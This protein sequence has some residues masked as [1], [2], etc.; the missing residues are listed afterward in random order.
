MPAAPTT[1]VATAPIAAM[2]SARMIAMP[3]MQMAMT[4]GEEAGEGNH[5]S[6]DCR[7]FQR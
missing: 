3:M 2:A 4:A 1:I 7:A 6:E 5:D